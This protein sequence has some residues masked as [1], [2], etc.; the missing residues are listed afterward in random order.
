MQCTVE[1]SSD[2]KARKQQPCATLVTEEN[3]QST[4][5]YKRALGI[6]LTYRGESQ[7]A[8]IGNILQVNLR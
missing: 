8:S 6:M 7:V 3:L 5:V 4:G 1:E 2:E